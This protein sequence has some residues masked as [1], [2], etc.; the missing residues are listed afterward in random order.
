MGFHA[1]S[2]LVFGQQKTI[3]KNL[4]RLCYDRANSIL[5]ITFQ[6]DDYMVSIQYFFRMLAAIRSRCIYYIWHLNLILISERIV[7]TKE[8][9]AAGWFQYI[10]TILELENKIPDVLPSFI[11]MNALYICF[12]DQEPC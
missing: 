10:I 5:V 4:Q 12:S 8:K 2:F 6:L 9:Q 7:C 3:K 11:S 1:P